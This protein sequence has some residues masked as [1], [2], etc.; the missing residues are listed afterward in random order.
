MR[1]FFSVYMAV[2]HSPNLD[3]TKSRNGMETDSQTEWLNFIAK[4]YHCRLV[5]QIQE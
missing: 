2:G 4:L 1:S 5:L 3:M